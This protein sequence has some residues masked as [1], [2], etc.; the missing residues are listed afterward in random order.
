MSERL[1]K[2]LAR[3]GLGSRRHCEEI[4]RAGQ[5]KVNGKTAS[6]GENVDIKTDAITVDSIPV[7]IPVIHRYIKLHKPTG[8]LSSSRSQGGRP[9]IYELVA[10]TERVYP[11][12]RLDLQSEGLILLTD[13]GDLTQRLSHPRYKHEK[14]YLVLFQ[15][16][17]TDEQIAHWHSGV[18]LHDGY[19]TQPSH[20][21]I[22][23]HEHGMT[24]CRVILSEGRKRQIRNMAS[25]L[26]LSVLRLIRIRIASLELGSLSPGKWQDCTA[27]EIE[28]LMVATERN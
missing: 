27:Q 12:G 13:D 9:T 26:G 19:Q 10:T 8:Y 18:Q 23:H 4:I 5:V 22:D 15:T 24:W 20:M 2:V 25:V 11:V 6:I 14:E 3:G 17:P 1:Q 21:V 28:A 7:Q 16:A